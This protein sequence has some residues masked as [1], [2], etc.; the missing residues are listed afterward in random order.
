MF[1]LDTLT[2]EE[3]TNWLSQNFGMELP[4]NAAYNPRREQVSKCVQFQCIFLSGECQMFE[5]RYITSENV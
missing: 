5:F 4:L 3:S 2:L 1:F